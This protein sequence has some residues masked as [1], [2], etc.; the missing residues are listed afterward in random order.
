MIFFISYHVICIFKKKKKKFFFF[1]FPT[2]ISERTWIKIYFDI[3]F[4]LFPM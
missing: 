4:L 2:T 1:L 3:G